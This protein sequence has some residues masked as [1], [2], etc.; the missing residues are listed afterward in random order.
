MLVNEWNVQHRK[1]ESHVET[2][3]RKEIEFYLTAKS[4][5]HVSEYNADFHQANVIT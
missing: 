5:V 3:R 4:A 2:L 1:R